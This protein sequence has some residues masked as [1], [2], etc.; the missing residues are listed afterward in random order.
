MLPSLRSLSKAELEELLVNQL[1]EKKFRCAQVYKWIY[2]DLAESYDAMTNV[3]K[4]LR[5]KLAERYSL[6]PFP[7]AKECIAPDGTN[8][9]AMTLQDGSVVEFVI[10]PTEKRLTLCVS[11][12][13]GCKFGCAFCRTATLGFGRR[14]TIDEILMQ[15]M[16]AQKIALRDERRLT[17]LV[18]MGM[19]EPLDNFDNVVAAIRILLDPDAFDF[20]KRKITLSTVGH[21]PGLQALA[22]Q[23]LG[24]NLAISLHAANDELRSK[25]M[26]ANRI[27]G[28]DELFM[29]L[30]NFPIAPRQRITFE[31]IL[32]R[33]L[34][35]SAADANQLS[36]RLHGIPAKINLIPFNRFD[37]CP[38]TTPTAD[39]IEKFQSLLLAKGLNT[40]LRISRGSEELAACGQ[41]GHVAKPC[42]C[43]DDEE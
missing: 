3:S 5:A 41:L 23:N 12:E 17:N 19:G 27:W 6:D 9:V 2:H 32:I 10:I 40:S 4:V 13:V 29:T 21:V 24:I 18:F 31:Y 22:R 30:K 36:R 26:P 37:G 42:E 35:H 14:L 39:E 33:G 20:S 7:P 15:V 8:K 34:N 28:L 38:F 25:I 1:D 11:S 16:V 43:E